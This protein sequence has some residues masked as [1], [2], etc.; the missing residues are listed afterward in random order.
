MIEFWIIT[1]GLFGMVFGSFSNV[2]VHRLPRR[3]S[4][5][6]P[7][8]NCP[9]C[10]A[11]IAW[12]DNIPVLSYLILRAKCRH[13]QQHIAMR[14]PLLEI[15]MGLCWSALVWHYGLSPTT[16]MAIVLVSLLLV[17]SII[18][19]ETELL[20][21]TL[22]FPGIALGLLY[23]LWAGDIYSSLIGA[24]AGYFVFW[25]VATVFFMLTKKHGMGGGDF[26]LLAML[27]AFLGWQS[28]PL[29]IL[30]ASL[31][32][33]VISVIYLIISRKGSQTRIR[34]GPFLAAAGIVWL[35]WGPQIWQWYLDLAKV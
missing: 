8:S 15:S 26:K 6:F 16:V 23:N 35:L 9:K 32:G 25:S 12:Y 14:Y 10:H 1:I 13:C 21:N 18:D 33:T 7:S 20:P 27:G 22:T 19:L 4:V 30:F 17:L 3:E 34:F 2:L 24:F 28:L 31:S 29:I 5:V 11:D